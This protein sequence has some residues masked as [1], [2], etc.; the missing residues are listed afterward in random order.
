MT[1]WHCRW[2]R[3]ALKPQ[4]HTMSCLLLLSAFSFLQIY[5]SLHMQT[6]AASYPQPFLLQL[7]VATKKKCRKIGEGK[8][9]K[10]CILSVH[11]HTHTHRY[12]SCAMFS[13]TE[14]RP[15]ERMRMTLSSLSLACPCCVHLSAHFKKATWGWVC[16]GL[17]WFVWAALEANAASL[18]GRR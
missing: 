16:S 10:C 14:G 17:V 2:H 12:N 15:G 13:Q 4:I 6:L 11:T 5:A 18:R 9:K 7:V 3:S 8:C 1:I